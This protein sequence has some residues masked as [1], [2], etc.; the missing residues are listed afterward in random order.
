MTFVVCLTSRWLWLNVNLKVY[1]SQAETATIQYN[2]IMKTDNEQLKVFLATI[3]DSFFQEAE[4]LEEERVLKAI[5]KCTFEYGNLIQLVK[6]GMLEDNLVFM[7]FEI[8]FELKIPR[9]RIKQVSELLMRLNN[10]SPMFTWLISYETGAFSLVI[11]EH[12]GLNDP[13]AKITCERI[14]AYATY[15]IQNKTA[16]IYKVAFGDQMPELVFNELNQKDSYLLN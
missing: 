14:N 15:L 1:L 13:T 4:V 7:C 3:H 2:L 5:E 9:E 10:E 11:T 6:L 16:A 8:F 12:M